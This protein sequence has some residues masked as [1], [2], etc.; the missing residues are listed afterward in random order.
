M[1]T[2]TGTCVCIAVIFTLYIS[3]EIC[4]FGYYAFANPDVK[5]NFGSHCWVTNDHYP[6]KIGSPITPDAVDGTQIMLTV[7]TTQFIVSSCMMLFL[8]L[9]YIYSFFQT[10]FLQDAMTFLVVVWI[11][12]TVSCDVWIRHV[13]FLHVVRVCSGDYFNM[14][15]GENEAERV[16]PYMQRSGALLKWI[17]GGQDIRYNYSWKDGKWTWSDEDACPSVSG[18][19][20]LNSTNATDCI[21]SKL[22]IKLHH[23]L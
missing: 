8:I 17:A 21:R 7:F 10:D 19:T 9:T 12:G 15:K 23:Y 13:R 4:A 14:R 1:D 18:L 6:M 11:I 20:N 5:D 2:Y 3:V 16:F 22:S